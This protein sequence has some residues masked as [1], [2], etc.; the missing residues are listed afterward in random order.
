[1]KPLWIGLAAGLVAPLAAAQA[2]IYKHVDE[3]GRITYTNR[4]MN[5]AV[6]IDLEPLSTVPGLPRPAATPAPFAAAAIAKTEPVPVPNTAPPSAESRPAGA[7][8]VAVVTPRILPLPAPSEAEAPAK[9]PRRGEKRGSL[10]AELRAEE[11]ALALVRQSLLQEQRNPALVAAVR[12]AQDAVEATPA[13]QAEMRAS[14]DKASGRIRGLQSTAAGHEKK[15]E[16][17][18]KALDGLKP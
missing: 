10:E 3:S 13:Q 2:T 1:M 8:P 12:Q 9:A 17:L 4:P 16:A 5:G 7:P 6:A 18:K 15:I 11:T 14:L